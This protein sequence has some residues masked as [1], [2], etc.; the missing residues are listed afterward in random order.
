MIHIYTSYKDTLKKKTIGFNI[1]KWNKKLIKK[2]KKFE[3]NMMDLSKNIPLEDALDLGWKILADCF[4]PE[5][6]GLKSSLIEEYWP[7]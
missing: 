2:K 5:E 7:K 3:D 1:S 4:E 6:T